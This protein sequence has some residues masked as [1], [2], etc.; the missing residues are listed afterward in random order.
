VTPLSIRMKYYGLTCELLRAQL[1]PLAI[2]CLDAPAAGGDEQGALQ[3]RFTQG[4]THGN[5]AYGA[6]VAQQLRELN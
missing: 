5:E 6:L 4:C 3:D 2:T 1:T